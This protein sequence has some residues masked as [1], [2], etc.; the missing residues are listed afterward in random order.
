MT[1]LS[2]AKNQPWWPAVFEMLKLGVQAQVYVERVPPGLG[3]IL[4]HKPSGGRVLFT[5][6]G[7][8]GWGIRTAADPALADAV[9]A[10][11]IK[12]FLHPFLVPGVSVGEA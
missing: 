3:H 2:W 5:S 10:G 8:P 11:G 6:L 12:P 9:G 4:T 7:L 1:L